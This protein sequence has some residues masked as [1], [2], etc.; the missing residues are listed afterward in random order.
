MVTKNVG[1]Y[2]IEI[3][4]DSVKKHGTQSWIVISKGDDKT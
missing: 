4:I 2:A 3:K 1:H